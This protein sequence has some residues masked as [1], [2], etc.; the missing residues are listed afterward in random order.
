[1]SQV[2]MYLVFLIKYSYWLNEKKYPEGK[3]FAMVWFTRGKA[4]F[5][6]RNCCLKSRQN[7]VTIRAL[8]LDRVGVFI[9]ATQYQLFKQT[10]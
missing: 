1:M 5:I 4:E 6:S 3:W 7:T 9:V 8:L 10:D 2:N